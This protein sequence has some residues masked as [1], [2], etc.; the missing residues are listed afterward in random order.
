MARAAKAVALAAKKLSFFVLAAADPRSALAAVLSAAEELP[1]SLR[2][3][4]L[5]EMRIA[6]SRNAATC[7]RP[8]VE[9]AGKL[10]PADKKKLE[11]AV[12]EKIGAAVT[13]LQKMN[14]DLIAGIRLCVGDRRWEFS[15]RSA[16][17]QFVAGC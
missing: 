15:I 9:Y 17:N 6:F 14:G 10:R 8:T 1:P 4:L 2:L 3:E 12:A 11:A 7:C 5:G 16:L 13:L